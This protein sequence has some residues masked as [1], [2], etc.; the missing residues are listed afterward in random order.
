LSQNLASDFEHFILE[1]K[2]L[3]DAEETL[4]LFKKWSEENK[5]VHLFGEFIDM[6]FEFDCWIAAVDDIKLGLRLTGVANRFEITWAD[7][8]FEYKEPRTFS[9]SLEKERGR[10]Y[11]SALVGRRESGERLVFFEFE[12]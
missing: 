9:E 11:V 10:S 4:L 8:S 2:S 6:V 12:E 7:F 1:E 5:P 3:I